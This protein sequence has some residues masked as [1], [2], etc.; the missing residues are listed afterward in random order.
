MSRSELGQSS[1]HP[2]S[3]RPIPPRSPGR[4]NIRIAT[5]RGLE[6]QANICQVSD[7]FCDT[8]QE[9]L[10]CSQ[11]WPSYC[12][13]ALEGPAWRIPHV[14]ARRA[15]VSILP[16]TPD[17]HL[18]SG[19]PTLARGTGGNVADAH[20]SDSGSLTWMDSCVP[21]AP[22]SQLGGRPS[23]LGSWATPW[24][25]SHWQ[26]PTFGRCVPLGCPTE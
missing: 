9:S 25:Q 17:P 20:K 13:P 16:R 2:H 11:K 22:I 6:E 18:S 26:A 5:M 15:S 19:W 14:W 24:T 21:V 3:S 7:T 10:C 23:A 4:R 1:P 12:R 8:P